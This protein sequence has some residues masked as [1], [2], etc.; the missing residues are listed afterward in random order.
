VRNSLI[1]VFIDLRSTIQEK[2]NPSR[3]ATGLGCG[4]VKSVVFIGVGWECFPLP[5][6]VGGFFAVLLDGLADSV[7]AQFDGL[8]FRHSGSPGGLR[9]YK[10]LI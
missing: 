4:R 8:A 2:K 1:F 6:E 10:E 3:L 7:F 5:D 9:S